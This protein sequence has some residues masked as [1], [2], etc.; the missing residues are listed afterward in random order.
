MIG[1]YTIKHKAGKIIRYL[2]CKTCGWKP[3]N[4]KWIE[5]DPAY[6]GDLKGQKRLRFDDDETKQPG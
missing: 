5:D 3:E 1:V 6:V 2:E 4:N